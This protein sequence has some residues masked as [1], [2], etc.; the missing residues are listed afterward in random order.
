M[1]R[2]RIV[3]KKR[4]ARKFPLPSTLNRPTEVV[5]ETSS[6][7][8]KTSPHEPQPKQVK[9]S[10]VVTYALARQITDQIRAGSKKAN[11]SS[12]S[13]VPD[14]P[15][16]ADTSPISESMVQD[17]PSTSIDSGASTEP[18]LPIDPQIPDEPEQA[19]SPMPLDDPMLPDEPMVADDPAT[20]EASMVQDEPI[21]PE[22]PI[23]AISAA[24]TDHSEG[25][26]VAPVTPVQRMPRPVQFESEQPPRFRGPFCP[27]DRIMLENRRGIMQPQMQG[28]RNQFTS[29][30]SRVA[31]GTALDLLPELDKLYD[32]GRMRWYMRFVEDVSFIKRRAADCRPTL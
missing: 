31:P 1:T 29:W 26:G 14:G 17:V 5:S 4:E 6:V 21:L 27:D 3:N 22:E 32:G 11:S 8:S 25:A 24:V 19:D 7:A 12:E 2:P 30:S 20:Q 18:V 16:D 10:N 23:T 9:T 15:T 28:R 13:A